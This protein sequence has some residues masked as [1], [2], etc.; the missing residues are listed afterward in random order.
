M[1]FS[2]LS[3][4]ASLPQ[5]PPSPSRFCSQGQYKL[6]PNPYR[7]LGWGV[8]T[9]GVKSQSKPASSFLTFAPNSQRQP[10]PSLPIT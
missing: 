6:L 3:I 5:L 4:P 7:K 8:V 9:G 2:H 10:S 1:S